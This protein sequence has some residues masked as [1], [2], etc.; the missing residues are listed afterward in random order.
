MIV[1][2]EHN[3]NNPQ[4]RCRDEHRRYFYLSGQIRRNCP[5]LQPNLEIIKTSFSEQRHKS[6][7]SACGLKFRDSVI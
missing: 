7:A 2:F 5:L 6:V 1:A 3:R 4:Y